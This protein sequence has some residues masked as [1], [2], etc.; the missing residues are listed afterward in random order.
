MSN[1]EHQTYITLLVKQL[2]EQLTAEESS[3]LNNWLNE[4]EEHRRMADD[5]RLTWKRIPVE[6]NITIR[7]N[8]DHAFDR[9]MGK[10]KAAEAEAPVVQP[11]VLK[12]T[13]LRPLT[14]AAAAALLLSASVWG[15]QKYLAEA[16]MLTASAENLEKKSVTLSD[17][18]VVWLRK[19]SQLKYPEQFDGSERHVELVGEAY[20]EVA[21]NPQKSFNIQTEANENIKVIGTSFNVKP[22]SSGTLVTVQSGTVLFEPTKG[23]KGTALTAG[24]QGLHKKSSTA[25]VVSEAV[26]MNDLAWQRDGLEF[27]DVPLKQV[28]KDLED[29]YKVQITLENAALA[30]CPYTAPLV[31]LPVDKVLE[32]LCT[33]YNIRLFN[34]NPGEFILRGGHCL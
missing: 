14:R 11:V 13:W 5:Y 28:V 2:S 25:I 22:T 8:L 24:K 7:P 18:T 9:L 20:F 33:V 3:L 27:V 12:T 29:Y 32:N 15:Y 16:P 21:P 30:N 10:I 6:E 31:Q 19:G 17:G 34:P 23:A 4:S 26:S 1:M